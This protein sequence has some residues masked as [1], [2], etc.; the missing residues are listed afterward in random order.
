MLDLDGHGSCVMPRQIKPLPFRAIVGLLY[1][2]IYLYMPEYLPQL[3]GAEVDTEM[4][5]ICPDL[6]MPNV[7]TIIMPI[8]F[9]INR[10]FV[11]LCY[12]DIHYAHYEYCHDINNVWHD[13]NNVWHT[14][15]VL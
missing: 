9:G 7:T 15:P 13:I 6:M 2:Y 12:G 5:W 8:T 10:S 3:L 14:F 4:F 11:Y 1:W